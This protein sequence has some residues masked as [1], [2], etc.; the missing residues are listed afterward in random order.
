MRRRAVDCADGAVADHECADV[1]SRFVDILLHVDGVVGVIAQRVAMF[2][3][4]LGGV[5]I[6]DARQQPSPRA[7][8]GFEHRRIANLSNRFQRAVRIE[9]GTRVRLRHAGH[10]QRQRRLQFIRTDRGRVVLLIVGTPQVLRIA[11]VYNPR[12]VLTARS[13]TRS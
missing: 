5:A 4:G 7:G 6:I 11:R 2:E 12:E 8:H 1:A 3:D 10:A 13:S 9:G